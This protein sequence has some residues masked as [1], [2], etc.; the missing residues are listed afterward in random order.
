MESLENG[1]CPG[2]GREMKKGYIFST[3]EIAW[4]VDSKSRLIPWLY[5]HETLVNSLGY[6]VEKVAA[7]RCENC[8]IVLFEYDDRS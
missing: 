2:C 3:R 7:C 6:K 1:K 4:T 8:C 5:Q